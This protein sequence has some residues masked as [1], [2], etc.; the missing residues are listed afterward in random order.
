MSALVRE[1]NIVNCQHLPDEPGMKAVLRLQPVQPD[2]AYYRERTDRNLGWITANEQ[3]MLRASVIGIAGCGG[4]GGLLASVF[5][6]LGV[7]EVRIADCETF[8]ISNINRQFGAKRGTVGRSKAFETAREVRAV[9][10]DTMLIVYPQGITEETVDHF[11]GGCDVICDEIELLALDARILLH[12]RSRAAGIPLFNCNTVG[13]GTNLFL[14]TPESMT[15][16]EAVGIGYEEAC[17]LRQATARGDREA[18]V[19]IAKAIL[20]AV[21]PDIPAYS[22]ETIEINREAVL[23]RIFEE[24]KA[25]IIATNPSMAGG[26]L[27]DRVLLYLLRNSGVRRDIAEIPA[28]PGYLHFDA[29]RMTAQA[30]SAWRLP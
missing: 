10:D 30:V 21:V 8:D 23:K 20:R 6:R 14:Y 3:S 22:Q 18:G 5:V 25:P 29:A 4:M 12:A 26:F 2:E 16:E 9:S 7:G 17:Q 1:L 27:A 28:M 11:A 15:M 13:F 24:G 19:R